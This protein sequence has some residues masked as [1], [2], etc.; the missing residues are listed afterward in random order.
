LIVPFLKEK[1]RN[2]VIWVSKCIKNALMVSITQIKTVKTRGFQMKVQPQM[3]LA[4]TDQEMIMVNLST[5]ILL[6][7]TSSSS[8][9]RKATGTLNARSQFKSV[10]EKFI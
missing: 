7:A 4:I 10:K 9:R 8:V 2:G 3:T 5:A 6:R 1:I